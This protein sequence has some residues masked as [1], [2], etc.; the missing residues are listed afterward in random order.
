V[1]GRA[2]DRRFREGET[3]GVSIRQARVSAENWPVLT[4]VV[5]AAF[6]ARWTALQPTSKYRAQE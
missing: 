2:S 5:V 3:T 1:Q 4:D 6:L